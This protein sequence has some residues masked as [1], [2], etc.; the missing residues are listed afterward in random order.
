MTT[1]TTHTYPSNGYY[2]VTLTATSSAPCSWTSTLA[3]TITNSP[4]NYSCATAHA[5]FTSII[6]SNSASFTNTSTNPS[7]LQ[8]FNINYTWYYGDGTN[9]TS[10][11]HTYATAGTYM[12]C[13]AMHWLDT[14]TYTHTIT[15]PMLHLHF[16]TWLT[17]PP[18]LLLP[19]HQTLSSPP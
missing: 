11:S 10:S 6:S 2:T 13:L 5:A 12:L 4:N 19:P 3:T 7:S 9:G 18:P 15:S 14:P 17:R 1:P 16:A 8:G